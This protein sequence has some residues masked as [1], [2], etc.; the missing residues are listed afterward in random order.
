MNYASAPM[1][2]ALRLILVVCCVYTVLSQFPRGQDLSD[3]LSLCASALNRSTN[4]SNNSNYVNLSQL[5]KCTCRSLSLS[6]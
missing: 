4:T 1:K 5:S 3:E 6:R 2:M